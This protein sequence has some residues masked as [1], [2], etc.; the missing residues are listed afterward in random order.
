M[1]FSTILASTLAAAASTVTAAPATK[2]G[3]F[4]ASGLNNLAFNSLDVG[5]L[6]VINSVDLALL[7]QLAVN[8]NLNAA[9]FANVFT[10]GV[11]NLNAV[12]QLQQLQVLLQ[13]G[14]LG[15]FNTFDL[16]TLNLELLQL[17]LIGNVGSFD[18]ST[19]IDASVVP[20]IT[21]I[22]QQGGVT[23]ASKE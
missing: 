5:Y 15:V 11:F 4:D 16:S 20:Q 14:Q 3:T 19:L 6:N 18:L 9:A 2:R 13:L 21:T 1:K 17:G 8:N 12:L 23:I 22:V 10:S 7:Q